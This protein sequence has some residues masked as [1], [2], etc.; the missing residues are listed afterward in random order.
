MVLNE[1]ILYLEDPFCV[2]ALDKSMSMYIVQVV[3]NYIFRGR[4]RQFR[5]LAHVK[6]NFIVNPNDGLYLSLRL[7]STSKNLAP[8]NVVRVI[9]RLVE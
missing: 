7:L 3:F 4:S 2:F 6:E 1:Y 8:P 9:L 5:I